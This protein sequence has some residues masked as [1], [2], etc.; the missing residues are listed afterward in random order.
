MKQETSGIGL[1]TITGRR[2]RGSEPPCEAVHKKEGDSCDYSSGFIHIL[3]TWRKNDRETKSRNILHKTVCTLWIFEHN[4]ARRQ[5]RCD[6]YCWYF[7][8][9]YEG[10]G[11]VCVFRQCGLVCRWMMQN[12]YEALKAPSA[13]IISVTSSVSAKKKKKRRSSKVLWVAPH[14]HHSAV[15]DSLALLCGGR[16]HRCSW[17]RRP[18]SAASTGSHH[19]LPPL[20]AKWLGPYACVVSYAAIMCRCWRFSVGQVL[21]FSWGSSQSQSEHLRNCNSSLFTLFKI[22]GVAPPYMSKQCKKPIEI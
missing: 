21:G 1:T 19:Q 13:C 5:A 2:C 11:C 8:M 9:M 7:H 18:S 4:V 20:E 15:P 17:S 22:C 14:G 16:S 3:L 12:T 6:I 10:Q